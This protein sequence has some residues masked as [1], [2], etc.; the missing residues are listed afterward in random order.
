ML[1]KELEN[2]GL[3]EK[4]AKVYL[5]LLELGQATAQ[6][7]AQKA[8]INRATAYFVINSLITKGLAASFMQEKKQFFIA[9]DPEKLRD[10][11]KNRLAEMEKNKDL[12]ENLLPE[13]KSINNQVKGKP[14]VKYYEGK[15][16]VKTMV[17]E[18][19]NVPNET[20]VLAYS[21]DANKDFFS[22]QERNEWIN[23]RK[24]NNIKAK[25]IYNSEQIVLHLGEGEKAFRVPSNKFPITCDIA[26]Y[27]NKIRLASLSNRLIGVVIEDEE[28][29]KSFRSIME[30]ALEAAEK[31]KE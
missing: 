5:A 3:N 30:L 14:V 4:E 18:V 13:L 17:A 21:A 9:S 19:F 26:V 24:K 16:G 20:I 15:E 25:V 29:A 11:L 23:I 27:G 12:L 10:V 31:Y 1:A 7:T 28:L 2:F 6:Q 8:G 22:A